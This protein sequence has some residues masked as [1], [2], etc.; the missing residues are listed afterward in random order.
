M[1]RFRFL[2]AADIHLD[3]P[4]RGLPEHDGHTATRIRHATR[5]AFDG[6]VDFAIAEAVDFVVIAGDLYD[7]DWKDY[8]TGLFFVERVGRL[9]EAGIPVYLLQGNHDHESPITRRLQLQL[10]PNVSRFGSRTAETFTIERLGVALH[11]RSFPQKAVTENLAAGYPA[12]LPGHFNIGVLHT[13]LGGLGGHENYA[14]CTL[15]E[16]V[17][18]GYDYWALGHVHQAQVLHRDPHVVF[19]GNLQGRN[20]RETGPK[21]A[22]LVEV[23]EGR[24]QATTQLALDVVRWADL[25]VDVRGCVSVA[26]VVTR[27]ATTLAEAVARDGDGRLLACRV[28]LQGQTPLH[29]ELLASAGTLVAEAWAAALGLGSEHAWIERVSIETVA[30][31]AA[32]TA[33]SAGDAL[34]DLRRYLDEAA[35]DE[36]LRSGVRTALQEFV[37]A[38]PAEAR[39]DVD[40]PVLAAA[41][42]G[43]VEAVM[44][45]ATDFLLG[46]LGSGGGAAP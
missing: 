2:H 17:N 1:A 11:G 16:L 8:R 28:R 36:P 22:V 5:E 39:R 24:V 46:R 13:A 43:D 6:L 23:D 19:P 9:R 37:A 41:L 44:A 12:P 40:D 42:A 18:R 15:A 45:G 33:R 26:E 21:G 32:G 30:P 20:V 27:I 25:G 38:L 4:L 34:G 10:P 7:G 14:P 31:V 35:G 3:S 29:G